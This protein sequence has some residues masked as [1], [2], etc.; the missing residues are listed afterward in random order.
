M[1]IIIAMIFFALLTVVDSFGAVSVSAQAERT[2]VAL[3]EQVI[4][5][6]SIKSSKQYKSLPV[7]KIPD[8]EHFTV[9]KVTKNSSGFTSSIQI[10]NGKMTKKEEII[11]YL[12]YHCVPK[13]PGAFSFPSLNFSIG[14]TVHSTGPVKIT[15]TKDVVKNPDMIVRLILNKKELYVGEQTL[16][17]V[18]VMRKANSAAAW[19]QSGFSDLID[20][21]D[22]ELGAVFSLSKLYGQ[23]LGRD[24]ERVGGEIY[25]VI[26]APYA[27]FPL[28]TGSF[29]INRIPFEF[30]EQKRIQSS[31]RRDPFFD[32]FFDGNFFGFGTRVQQIPK[33]VL[34]NSLNVSIKSIPSTPPDFTGSVGN[35][36]LEASVDPKSVPAGEAI[37]LKIAVKGNS[38]PGSIGEPTIPTL[39]EFEVFSPEKHTFVD[40]TSQRIY[41]RKTY[42]YLAIP[43]REGTAV[44]PPIR[45][46]Y[47]DPDARAFKTTSSDTLTVA[48]TKGK[49]KSKSRSRYLTQEEIR[50]VG[51]DIRYIKTSTQLHNQPEKPYR[52][53][54][55]FIVYPL[56]F[57]I[58][59]F[60]LL[61]RVQSQRQKNVAGN[62][63]QKALRT[64]HK[65]LQKVSQTSGSLSNAE[66]LG[67]IAGII[68]RYI[69]HKF[70]FPATGKMLDELRAE[71]I[72]RGINSEIVDNLTSFISSLDEYRFGGG[73]LDDNAKNSMIEKTRQFIEELEKSSARAKKG[74]KNSV[75]QRVFLILALFCAANSYAAPVERWVQKANSFYEQKNYDS[76]AVYY[77]KIIESGISNSDVY[78]NLGNAYFRL[79]Q[80]GEAILYYE[81]AH[82]L[83]PGDP[84]ITT[85][86]KF[87]TANIIDRAPEP[88]RGFLETVLWRLHTALSLNVQLWLIFW[89]LLL[90][91]ILF[92]LGLF[93]SHNIRLWIIYLSSL[94]III[95]LIT[96]I[97]TGYKIY[98]AEK[99]TYAIVLDR[100]VD[101]L[102]QPKGSKVLFTAHEGIKFHIR[103]EL[104]DW[105][106]VS[107]PNGVSGWVE[108]DGL[109]KI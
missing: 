16:L 62:L 55:F 108:K 83:S 69:S 40:T 20:R 39:P 57:L 89:I 33:S 43:N 11:Y 73:S 13:K 30:V 68:E 22:K 34:S 109:G 66:V 97:S 74:K 15:V 46:V 23:K 104:G 31:R 24:Q 42:K 103:K 37:T 71:L 99:V 8:N 102:N 96:G 70:G 88:E 38:R 28:S 53:P 2:R 7:P 91:S 9:A 48:V 6:V 98:Q 4:V 78:Y 87:A 17:M 25:E 75:V 60:S 107:L 44:I 59:V 63:K 56:P 90:L 27:A 49:G 52:K 47:F 85:N 58:A 86:I 106:L 14:G 12:H 72:N 77:E 51:R 81:K 105:A 79:R 19:T 61:F 18:K 80:L 94:L 5:T 32:D 3:G 100:S 65:E 41:A 76:A 84:D 95:A 54:L 64:A 50:E 92:A 1:R 35:F 93:V 45:L 21:I 101:A 82:K 67:K 26:R 36:T 10:I 29:T